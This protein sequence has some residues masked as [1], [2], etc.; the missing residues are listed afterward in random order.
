MVARSPAAHKRI[1]V[2]Y[3]AEQLLGGHIGLFALAIGAAS[4]RANRA[5]ASQSSV[6]FTVKL[7]VEVKVAP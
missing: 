5:A 4:D 7:L 3:C 2:A 6:F 1:F